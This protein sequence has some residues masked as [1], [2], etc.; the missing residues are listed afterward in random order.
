MKN[1]IDILEDL[2]ALPSVNPMGGSDSAPDL[3][4]EAKVNDYMSDF[5]GK[6]G[7]KPFVQET[8]LPG[9]DN[10]GA[11]LYKGADYKT[12]IL[13]CHTDTVGI[14]DNRQL[15][16]PI[17]KNSRIYGRGACDCKGGL[18]A[19][20]AALAQAAENPDKVK[21]NVIVMGVSDEEYSFKGSLALCEQ[22][23]SKNAAFGIIGEPTGCRV[24]N[25]FKGVARWN[26]SV[27]GKAFHSSE[28]EKGVNAIY[29]MAKLISLIEKYQSELENGETIS[30]G[31]VKG[32]SAVNIVPD[33]C[34][35]EIDRRLTKNTSPEKAFKDLEKYLS[36][37]LDFNFSFSDLKDAQNAILI[38]PDHP[39]VRILSEICKDMDI[40]GAP[41]Q[42]AFGSDAYRMN[43]AGIPTVLWGPG[44]IAVAHTN[45]EY[46]SM[47]DLIKAEEFYFRAMN[48]T[49]K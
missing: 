20:L 31:T 49:L 15:L 36:R 13:Q 16:R 39:G 17:R 22:E 37:S 7:L 8:A 27:T 41:Q 30:V 28:P 2:I 10:V 21:N 40:D 1:V 19:M 33:A 25:G 26:A 32:G 5:I 24:V 47:D 38:E 9:R 12:V 23:P 48:H 6:I 29:R 43:A 3:C 42:V 11:V 34:T 18:A 14:G 35:I 4:G 45:D 46:V 44:S